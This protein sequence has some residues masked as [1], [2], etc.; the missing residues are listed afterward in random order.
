[1]LTLN[2]CIHRQFIRTAHAVETLDFDLLIIGKPRSEYRQKFETLKAAFLENQFLSSLSQ[3]HRKYYTAR[4]PSL[5]LI[6]VWHLNP[7]GG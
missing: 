6:T 5:A 3:K 1:M 7:Q 2:Y 4:Q